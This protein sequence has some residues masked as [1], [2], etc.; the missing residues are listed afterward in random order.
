M[1]IFTNDSVLVSTMHLS[2]I[3]SL[4]PQ[5]QFALIHRTILLNLKQISFVR[6]NEVEL[7]SQITVPLS[8]HRV[9]EFQDKLMQYLR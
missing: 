2:D 8:K 1:R 5:N 3:T 7:K 9:A 6:K 4:L